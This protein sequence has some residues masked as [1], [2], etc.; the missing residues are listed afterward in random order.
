MV[1]ESSEE[2]MPT[3]D[4]KCNKCDKV[5]ERFHGINETP[6]VICEK[7]SAVMIRMIGAGSGVIFKGD[8]W[9]PKHF[10]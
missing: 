1:S 6:T 10:K 4:Y 7:C 3:Y 2:I 5:Q 8:G 9:T